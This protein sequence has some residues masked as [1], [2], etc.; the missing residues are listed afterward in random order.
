MSGSISK[1]IT[2]ATHNRSSW[3]RYQKQSS[4]KRRV[5]LGILVLVILAMVVLAGKTINFLVSS[6]KAGA[7]SGKNYS[8]DGSS[9]IN[10]VIKSKSLSVVSYNPVNNNLVIAKIPD[11]TYLNVPQ[12]FGRWP[13]RSVY[14]LGQGENPPVGAKLLKN[15]ISNT[16]GIPIDG[17][18]GAGGLSDQ[19]DFADMAANLKQNPLALF[20]LVGQSTTDLNLWEELRFFWGIRGVRFDRLT[21]ID[22]GKSSITE[23]VLLPDS[24][25]ALAFDS[26]KLD[27]FIQDK[28]SET[29]LINEGL[30]VAILNSTNH[31]G[32]AEKAA[33]VI[34][35][36]GGRVILTNNSTENL[37]QTVITGQR[38]FTYTRLAQ[39]FAPHC[40]TSSIWPFAKSS[41]C[42]LNKT[43][44]R[45]DIVIILGEDYSK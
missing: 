44:P 14:A 2:A 20:S 8:W 33:R 21:T 40:L 12:G 3:K 38:S 23:S 31:P 15:T 16:F 22:L 19:S 28:F 13:A 29:K 34:T 1:K 4:V 42:G 30:S 18:I 37:P 6:G 17:F 7:V 25:R 26:V 43:D 9:T 32:L 10:L 11:D 41:G 27:K 35:N 36:M 45:A 39:I 24:S 5:Y